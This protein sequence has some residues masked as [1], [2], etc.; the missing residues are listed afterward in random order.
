MSMPPQKDQNDEDIE[1]DPGVE[2]RL[3]PAYTVPFAAAHP[4]VKDLTLMESLW[5]LEKDLQVKASMRE[6]LDVRYARLLEARA[7]VGEAAGRPVE[8]VHAGAVGDKDAG[9]DVADLWADEIEF[10]RDSSE[11]EE[12]YGRIVGRVR[13]K[14]VLVTTLGHSGVLCIAFRAHMKKAASAYSA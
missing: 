7:A 9:D 11:G 1:M 3:A 6:E 2:A 4:T 14:S 12:M 10:M 8:L 13:Q 5:R